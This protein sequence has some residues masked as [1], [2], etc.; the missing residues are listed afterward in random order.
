V[1]LLLLPVHWVVVLL[2]LISTAACYI[3]SCRC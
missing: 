3:R 2:L 1:L